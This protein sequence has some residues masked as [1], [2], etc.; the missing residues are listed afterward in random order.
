MWALKHVLAALALHYLF[1]EATGRG[2]SH[3]S[4]DPIPNL[5]RLARIASSDSTGTL[6]QSIFNWQ[7]FLPEAQLRKGVVHTGA[8]YRLRRVLKDLM[9]GRSK[10]PI[11]IGVVGGSISW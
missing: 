9:D 3:G 4:H 1:V 10:K 11:K 2:L 7:Y 6:L 8:N 5:H